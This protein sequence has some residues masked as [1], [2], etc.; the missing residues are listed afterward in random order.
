MRS[1]LAGSVL[2]AGCLLSKMGSHLAS[3]G[4]PI[5]EVLFPIPRDIGHEYERTFKGMTV[6]PVALGGTDCDKGPSDS[7]VA[8][9][10]GCR[11][12]Q[13]SS[14]MASLRRVGRQPEKLPHRQFFMC[15]LRKGCIVDWRGSSSTIKKQVIVTRT[16]DQVVWIVGVDIPAM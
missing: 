3:H 15:L 6:E 7:R 8:T 13:V 4:R 16:C 14:G 9:G 5:H 11:G 10:A 1:G 2:C 12:A